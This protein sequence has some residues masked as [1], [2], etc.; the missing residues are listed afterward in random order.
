M[1]EEEAVRATRRAQRMPSSMKHA[2]RSNGGKQGR[3]MAFRARTF[4]GGYAFKQLKGEIEPGLGVA[5]A[6]LPSRAIVPLKETFGA[7]VPAL[8]SEGDTVAAGQIIGRDDE[9]VSTPIHA[10]VSGRVARIFKLATPDGEVTALEIKSD[11]STNWQ[12]V[13]RKYSD[14]LTAPPE[15]LAE[16]LYLAGVTALGKKGIPTRFN[17]SPVA[18]D[19]VDALV[20]SAV[21]SEPYSLPNGAV[22]EPNLDV[23]VS[24]VRIL[25]RVFGGPRT[26]ISLDAR[27]AALAPKLES[28]L[29]ADGVEVALVQPKFPAEYDEVLTEVLLG[30]MVP[31]GGTGLDVGALVVDVQTCLA[32]HAACVEGKPLIERVVALGGTGYKERALVKTRIGTP[33][34]ELV[35]GRLV[36]QSLLVHNGAL[37]GQPILNGDDWPVRRATWGLTALYDDTSRPFMGWMAPGFDFDSTSRVFASSYFPPKARRA[38]TNLAGELRP[39]IQCGY[40]SEVCPR[41]LLP[42]QL[43]RV[44]SI[45]ELDEA[46]ELRLFGCIECGLCSYV[47]VSKI[48][49]MTNIIAGKRRVH[50]EHEAE[51]AELAKKQAEEEARQQAGEARQQA[52]EAR[53]QAGEARQQAGEARQEAGEA[54]QAAE[55]AENKQEGDAA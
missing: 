36:E 33:A 38:D 26:I 24:G 25:Q 37:A 55:A 35:K 29:S 32:A 7:E 14:P 17:S 41:D 11:G 44:L 22:L 18:P 16:T 50:E 28:M 51:Q 2:H 31:D 39:C 6:P 48:P 9:L 15:Q 54:R 42:F 19:S 8:V 34:H 4:P 13:E 30:R 20:V 43:D 45:D 40:C 46:E 5:E 52:G 23:F 10:P 49:L 12:P 53:Q 1:L 27:D 21:H 3:R 47:C